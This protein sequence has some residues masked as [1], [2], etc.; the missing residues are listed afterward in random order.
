MPS[1]I[2]GF[3]FPSTSDLGISIITAKVQ[4]QVFEI[5][6]FKLTG[7]GEPDLFG[8]ADSELR[9]A[10]VPRGVDVRDVPSSLT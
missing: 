4:G 6:K 5:S 7:L 9:L 3:Y 2:T 1:F 10:S 8:D